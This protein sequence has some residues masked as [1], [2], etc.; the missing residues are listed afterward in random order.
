[1]TVADRVNRAPAAGAPSLTAGDVTNRFGLRPA[2]LSSDGPMALQLAS[3]IQMSAALGSIGAGSRLRK[4]L[5]FHRNA[6]ATLE[7]E[8]LKVHYAHVRNSQVPFHCEFKAKIN[9]REKV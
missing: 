4:S 7:M 5:N 6:L 2:A 3:A 9:K 1:M 8:T